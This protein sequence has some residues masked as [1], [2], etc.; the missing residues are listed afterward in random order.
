M[1]R[2]KRLT[3][4]FCVFVLL[5]GFTPNESFDMTSSSK[6]SLNSKDFPETVIINNEI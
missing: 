5:T 1:K 3:V 6:S 2:L 4:L